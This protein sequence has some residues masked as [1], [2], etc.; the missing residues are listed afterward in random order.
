MYNKT[1]KS[2]TLVLPP[3]SMV[4]ISIYFHFGVIALFLSPFIT[5]GESNKASVL[6]GGYEHKAK[7]TEKIQDFFFFFFYNSWCMAAE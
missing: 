7:F 1:V 5:C 4:S 2:E 3:L 6:A